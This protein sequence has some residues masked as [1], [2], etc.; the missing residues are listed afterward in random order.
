MPDRNTLPAL[1]V[2]LTAF[3]SDL[4][5]GG[6]N[7]IQNTLRALALARSDV[8]LTL[9]FVGPDHPLLQD[10]LIAGLKPQTLPLP[11][12][13][14]RASW[15]DIR[16]EYE[17]RA[18]RGERPDVLHNF[19][20]PLAEWLDVPAVCWI[21]DFQHRRRPE[22]FAAWEIEGRE[23]H[24]GRY[25]R[26]S[27]QVVVSSAEAL[28][29]FRD[30]WPDLAGKGRVVHFSSTLQPAE[31]AGTG[32][33]PRRY[34]LDLPYFHVVNQFW[35]HK[36]HALT[37]RAAAL[38]KA[39]GQ[40]FRLVMTGP[41][42]D[43]RHPTFFSELLQLVSE[44]GLREECVMLGQV[45]RQELFD[46][47][48]GS[49]CVL[50]PS[51]VEGWNTA[52]EE[53][54]VLRLPVLASDIPVHREQAGREGLDAAFFDA[55]DPVDLAN[56]MNDVLAGRLLGQAR[57]DRGQLD[58]GLVKRMA[59]QYARELVEVWREAAAKDGPGR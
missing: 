17:R 50:Q 30:A 25:A 15:D 35:K 10:P 3:S 31:T 56:R 26:E 53:C 12:S 49:L 48:R 52:L 27:R 59:E 39:R 37:I 41:L 18:A 4:W 24:L 58:S 45:P 29:D 20:V 36:N 21:P 22:F 46:L 33:A 19:G 7:Y 8:K 28:H 11:G 6:L 44:L 51:L 42:Y 2:G 5:M 38:L 54:R 1:H 32:E 13:Q 9:Y 14:Q 16:E 55:T 40:R 23:R 57:P 34:G 43:Y 47:A